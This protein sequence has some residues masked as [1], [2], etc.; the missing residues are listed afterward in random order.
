[1]KMRFEVYKEKEEEE[2]V[3]FDL[4]K[5]GKSIYLQQ[6]N[7]NGDWVTCSNIIEI[8]PDGKLQRCIGCRAKGI[9][10]GNNNRIIMEGE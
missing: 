6:V 4:Q 2:I 9:K 1:M 8:T 10:T 7:E 5:E 3:Y